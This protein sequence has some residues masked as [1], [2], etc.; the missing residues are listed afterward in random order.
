LSVRDN[1][2]SA[3]VRSLGN[4]CEPAT[5]APLA[6]GSH[7]WAADKSDLLTLDRRSAE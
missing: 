6:L 3:A 5:G 4:R 2:V 1:L 7:P